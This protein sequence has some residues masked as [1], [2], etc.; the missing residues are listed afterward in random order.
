MDFFHLDKNLKVSILEVKNIV[1]DGP[2]NIQYSCNVTH[3]RN[4]IFY[5][6]TGLI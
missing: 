3:E 4:Y 6:I 5:S 2:G 1:A